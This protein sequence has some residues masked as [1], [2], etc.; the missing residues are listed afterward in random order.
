MKSHNLLN[1]LRCCWIDIYQNFKI[2][3]ISLLSYISFNSWYELVTSSI[4]IPKTS[5]PYSYNFVVFYFHR[6][7]IFIPF[8]AFTIVNNQFFFDILLF[9]NLIIS[10]K[11]GKNQ[12]IKTQR[13]VV[14]EGRRGWDTISQVI[15]SP[16]KPNFNIFS[17]SYIKENQ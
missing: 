15:Y 16:K 12:E 3:L 14:E 2:F 4:S 8:Y 7:E 13:K 11:Y 6:T 17:W 5:K 1:Y 9:F 10:M